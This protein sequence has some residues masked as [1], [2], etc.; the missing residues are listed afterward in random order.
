MAL[1]IL[2]VEIILN[3]IIRLPT[4]HD[5]LRF[6]TNDRSIL[7]IFQYFRFTFL[8]SYFFFPLI[9]ISIQV[10]TLSGFFALSRTEL[11][12]I[13]RP[14][15]SFTI[16]WFVRAIIYVRFKSQLT[17]QNWFWTADAPSNI[18]LKNLGSA[19]NLWLR[20]SGHRI[21]YLIS[22]RFPS[23]SFAAW[24]GIRLFKLKVRIEIG[25]TSRRQISHI[26]RIWKTE[27]DCAF[28]RPFFLSL[29]EDIKIFCL[30]RCL[31]CA[32][33]HGNG[34][35]LLKLNFFLNVTVLSDEFTGSFKK[36]LGVTEFW[37]SANQLF[38][39]GYIDLNLW[40]AVEDL[41][42]LLRYAWN[43]ANFIT[44]SW[45]KHKCFEWFFFIFF[46]VME[47]WI[48]IRL[49][50]SRDFFRRETNLLFL[51]LSL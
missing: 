14:L 1:A 37:V 16:I 11:W 23:S 21:S 22:F 20:K 35:L 32:N 43:L 26:H 8:L 15:F 18:W 46:L 9:Q 2:A 27:I 25:L 10:K 34:L 17:L 44:I 50:I 3:R 28:E 41:R 12:T 36:I 7:N 5:H 38:I 49:V 51:R 40:Y 42:W 33:C 31:I 45:W 13:D 6:C 47:I 19:W 48:W 29:I 24:W 4:F 39:F 30:T